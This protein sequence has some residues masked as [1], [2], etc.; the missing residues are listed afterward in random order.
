V[1]PGDLRGGGRGGARNVRRIRVCSQQA[2]H[3]ERLP[4]ELQPVELP[5][6]ISKTRHRRW[7]GGGGGG[8][9]S[10]LVASSACRNSTKELRPSGALISNQQTQREFGSEVARQCCLHCELA[11]AGLAIGCDFEAAGSHGGLEK[12]RE[13]LLCDAHANWYA[14]DVEALGFAHS[15]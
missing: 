1:G 7:G 11:D 15:L 3:F 8:T 4:H 13:N 5:S 14:A 12:A 10:A 2:A 9:L 6:S